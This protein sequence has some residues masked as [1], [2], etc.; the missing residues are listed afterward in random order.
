MSQDKQSRFLAVA[1]T[2]KDVIA[3]VCSVYSAPGASFADL[4]QEVMANLWTGLDS[5]RGQAKVSTWIYRI[6]I[7]TCLT[8][9]RRNNRHSHTSPLDGIEIAAPSDDRLSQL[10]EL[11]RLI[12]ML[13]P[14]DK[15]LITLWLDERPYDEIAEIL[16]ISRT[17]VAVRLHRVRQ[18]LTQMANQ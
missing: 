2:Y 16:G 13:G 6:A 9:H 5:F 18:R 1:D 7:N 11:Y 15:A 4:Y 17:N 10:A 8:W 3:K 14:V 12:D